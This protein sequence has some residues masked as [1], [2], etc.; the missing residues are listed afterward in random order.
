M[1][2]AADNGGSATSIK[3]ASTTAS[4]TSTGILFSVMP[5]QRIVKAVVI[6]LIAVAVDPTLVSRMLR[7]Q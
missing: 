7:I 3:P 6:K 1:T 4:H 2:C 5:G